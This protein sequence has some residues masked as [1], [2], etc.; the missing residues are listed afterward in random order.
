M[1]LPE[2]PD[3]VPP[4]TVTSL[5]VKFVEASDKVKLIVAVAPAAKLA[6]LEATVNTHTVKGQRYPAQASGEVDTEAL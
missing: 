3:S 5:A 2:K 1:P 4:V 6:L